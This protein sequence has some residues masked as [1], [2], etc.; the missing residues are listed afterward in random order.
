V[1][2]RGVHYPKPHRVRYISRQSPL[3]VA[4]RRCT[5]AL[6]W[7][8]PCARV[9]LSDNHAP[10]ALSVQLLA[11]AAYGTGQRTRLGWNSSG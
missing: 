1:P 10:H 11:L 7:Y 5:W 2:E 6:G 3:S 4:V 9:V 8:A